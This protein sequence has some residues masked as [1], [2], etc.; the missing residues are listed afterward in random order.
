MHQ[1]EK[2]IKRVKENQL[3][4]TNLIIHNYDSTQYYITGL[5]DVKLWLEKLFTKMMI[6]N[7]VKNYDAMPVAYF[8]FKESY[9]RCIP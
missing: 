6:G 8:Q 7:E 2:R 1:R 4:I 5:S 9:L 3:F